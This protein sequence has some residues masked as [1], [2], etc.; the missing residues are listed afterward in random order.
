MLRPSLSATGCTQLQH[1]FGQQDHA[2]AATRTAGIGACKIEVCQFNDDF[3]C[4]TESIHVGPS[5]SEIS[6]LTVAPRNQVTV[7]IF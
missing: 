5:K 7:T 2:K 4:M 6:Y 3:E 1:I